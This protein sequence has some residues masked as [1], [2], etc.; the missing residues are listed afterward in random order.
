MTL[1][2]RRRELLAT[3]ALASASMALPSPV[4]C[5]GDYGTNRFMRAP[6]RQD[7]ESIWQWLVLLIDA[8]SSMSKTFKRMSFYAMQVEATARALVEP[9]VVSRLIGSPSGRTAIGVILWSASMQ[10]EIAVHWTVIRSIED[11]LGVAARLR[12]TANYLD[13]YTGT[14]AAVRFATEQL[15]AVYIPPGC[16]KII[17][18]SANGRDNQGGDPARE[19]REAERSGITINAVVMRGYDGSVEKMYE[20]YANNVVTRDGLVFKVAREDSALEALA[21]ANASKF[22]AEIAAAPASA[23]LPA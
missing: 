1:I 16:R 3:A 14:A 11:V 19:A 20:Y 6:T 10:Q 13:S 5:Y 4:A 8:S 18:I 23:G 9:C 2:M 21:V 7:G 12:N 17:N 15:K 22:C